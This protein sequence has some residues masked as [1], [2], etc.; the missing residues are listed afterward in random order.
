MLAYYL[1]FSLFLPSLQPEASK[2]LSH[3]LWLNHPGENLMIPLQLFPFQMQSVQG[4]ILLSF[5]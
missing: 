2:A 3:Q 1:I 5:C 4:Q